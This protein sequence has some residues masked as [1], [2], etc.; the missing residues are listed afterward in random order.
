MQVILGC[1]CL[2]SL[3]L[4]S[5]CATSAVTAEQKAGIPDGVT[6]AMLAEVHNNPSG[7]R[8]AIIRGSY[9]FKYEDLKN[10]DAVIIRK[11]DGSTAMSVAGLPDVSRETYVAKA[12][13]VYAPITPEPIPVSFWGSEGSLPGTVRVLVE[14]SGTSMLPSTP[15]RAIVAVVLGYPYGKLRGGQPVVFWNSHTNGFTDHELVARFGDRW[16][17]QGSNCALLPRASS[18]SVSGGVVTTT[19]WMKGGRDPIPM[20]PLTYVGA[21]GRVWKDLTR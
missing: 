12:D 7:P 17:T 10:G 6:W 19:T 11:D 8:H 3:F 2:G 15:E 4:L 5:G 13:G 16:T 1:A 18:V 14:T 9:L 20:T 21:V